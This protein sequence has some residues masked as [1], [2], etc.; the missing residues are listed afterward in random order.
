MGFVSR[1]F[2]MH[3]SLY[4]LMM[5]V[6]ICALK[7]VASDELDVGSENVRIGGYG[8][9]QI[10][11]IV[12]GYNYKLQS[13]VEH[14]WQNNLLIG[15]SIRATP[16]EH[17]EIVLSPEFYL[18][19]PF[20]QQNN[21]PKS[22]R[23]FGIA[24][25]NEARG[26]FSFG[27]AEE[28]FLKLDLGM[29]TFKYNHEVRNLGEYLFRTGTYPTYILN[30]FDF[31]A[32][33]L[34]GLHASF[35]PLENLHADV[36]F[37]TEAY[38]YPLYDFSLTGIVSY[39]LFNALDVGA[40]IDFARFFPVS[41]NRTSPEYKASD[42]ASFNS[43]ITQN[44][45]TSFYSFK[46]TKAMVR[47][48]IDIKALFGSSEIFGAEDLKLYGEVC[49]VGIGGYNAQETFDSAQNIAYHAWYNSLNERT[50]RMIGLN[51]P[52][53]KALDVLSFEFEYFPSVIPNDFT[54]VNRLLTPV[55]YING[56]VNSYN[57]DD[58]NDGFFRWS[59][60]AKRMIVQGFSIAGEA[61]FDHF[62]TTLE[63]GSPFEGESL[64]K[65]GNWHW[66]LKFG[67]AF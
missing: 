47:A 26:Q 23:P 20:P 59:L 42:N 35:D 44:G 22:V 45:D 52:T 7:G 46:A 4:A 41:D 1:R 65:A 31:P 9:W 54:N 30:D 10:G 60:Y 56:G 66:K 36:L 58:Y 25:I 39:K 27:N 19:Y 13:G 28:P 16:S 38:M 18:N 11:Q 33:R 50:P 21:S 51:I 14:E 15:L 43:Y 49:W 62:R 3:V 12:D 6:S 40:G 61:A 32:A 53:F 55:P 17:L 57:R 5:M 37:T 34:L 2:F 24:Y 48:A 64:T 63:D 67:Y 29:F 8:Y